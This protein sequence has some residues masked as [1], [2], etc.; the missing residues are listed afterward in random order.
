MANNHLT[1]CSQTLR[2]NRVILS[3][4]WLL[5]WILY[6]C[7]LVPAMASEKDKMLFTHLLKSAKQGDAAAQYNLGVMYSF[8]QGAPQDYK[9]AIKWFK[10]AAKQG[11]TKAKYNVAVMY[12]NG[13]GVR[14]DRKAAIKW[15]EQAALDGLVEAQYNLGVLHYNEQGT[16]KEHRIAI[17]WL[18]LAAQQSLGEAQFNLGIMYQSG[19][20]VPK[21]LVY[22]YMWYNLAAYNDV[23]TAAQTRDTLNQLMSSQQISTAQSLATACLKK[24]YKN[25]ETKY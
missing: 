13:R 7:L 3:P 23:A 16:Q 19:H 9:E 20:G 4:K 21:D 8:G 10:L 17:K 1:L 5:V 12:D 6:L 22:A 14:P 18:R 11:H 24:K 25:C 2:P 15:Y